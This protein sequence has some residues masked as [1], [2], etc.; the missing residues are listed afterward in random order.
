MRPDSLSRPRAARLHI[1]ELLPV[2]ARCHS[3]VIIE[4]RVLDRADA[5]PDEQ[6]DDHERGVKVTMVMEISMSL[7]DQ[8]I[9]LLKHH[10]S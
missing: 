3:V 2:V 7:H 4:I 5:S 10:M 1:G 8:T 6:G 9:S